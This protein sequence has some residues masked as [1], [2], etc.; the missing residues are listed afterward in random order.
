MM[1]Q[2]FD[3]LSS[4]D[5]KAP[6]KA[7]AEFIGSGEVGGKARSLIV[8]D[9]IVKDL[10]S[11]KK[12]NDMEFDIPDFTVLRT[13]VFDEFMKMNDLYEIALSETDDSRMAYRFQQADL[14]FEVLKQLR[15]LMT[16]TNTPLA[17]RSS[18][19]L[20]DAKYEPF[21]GIYTTK[22][23]PNNQFDTDTRCRKLFEAIKLVYASVFFRSP[24]DYLKSTGHDIR[25]E[26][27]AV[28]I[29]EVIG[30]KHGE[31]FYP[32]VSGVARSY[33]FYPMGRSKPEDGVVNLAV[34]LGKTIV[35]GGLSWSYSPEDPDQSPPFGSVNDILKNTQTEFW[36]IRMSE[37]EEYDP[38]NE[39]EYM[40]K[41]NI[42]AAEKDKALSLSASTLCESGRVSPGMGSDGPRVINFAPALKLEMLPL[43]AAIKE[44]L[45]ICGKKFETPVE[46]EFA[47]TVKGEGYDMTG[48][49]GFLQ[50]RPMVVSKEKIDISEEDFENP[51]GVI[52]T[53]FA[54]GN[55]M[56]ECIR[57]IIYVDPKKFDAKNTKKIAAELSEMNSLLTRERRKYLLIGFGR[58]GSSD[59]WLGIP[60]DWG[61]ISSSHTIVEAGLPNMNVELSQGSHFFHNM[62][63]F[64]VNYLSVPCY[65]EHKINWD[66]LEKLKVVKKSENVIWADTRSPLIIKVDGRSGRAVVILKNG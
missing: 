5:P 25:E 52:A 65:Y 35:D 34:G 32:D 23:L 44:F 7:F 40:G 27:M 51:D 17:I 59:H 48:R 54:L 62:T 15:E 58:W 39:T 33:N 11:K 3:F 28:I 19:L 43:N 20:E 42:S 37:P 21:A 6:K 47:V 56:S 24:K 45:D 30:R 60:V 22:M 16:R 38:V 2:E 50:V 57:D 26:K 18:S 55:G 66:I 31:R 4:V 64:G 1:A 53:E 63:S 61:Q 12:Y 36:H 8:A 10:N 29:Q 41:I 14:P 49:F 13:G 9:E 46:I